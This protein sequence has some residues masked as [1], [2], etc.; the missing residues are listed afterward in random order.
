MNCLL[1]WSAAAVSKCELLPLCAGC[2]RPHL[3]VT[4]GRHPAAGSPAMPLHPGRWAVSAGHRVIT[5]SEIRKN[6]NRVLLRYYALFRRADGRGGRARPLLIS[7]VP[8]NIFTAST[9][10]H[11]YAELGGGARAGALLLG[12]LR[13]H[14]HPSC[15]KVGH[16]H[17][18]SF[19]GKK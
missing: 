10:T 4:D 18:K 11:N 12:F 13:C 15:T 16:Q 14:P 17:P 5:L 9:S 6:V 8:S 1:L 19:C 2:R 7:R 3:P